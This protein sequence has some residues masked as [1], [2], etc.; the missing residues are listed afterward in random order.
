MNIQTKKILLTL[1]IGVALVLIFL[2]VTEAITKYTGYAINQESETDFK[3]CL[4][5]KDI[6]LYINTLEPAQTIKNFAV[7]DY[8]D[9]IKIMNCIRNNDYCLE[10]GL[11]S[12]PTWDIEGNKIKREIS[13]EELSN[14]SNCKF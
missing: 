4:E 1:L 10:K 13:L 2:L 3:S 8:V 7:V 5:N 14:F 12:F 6:T 9:S 11:D